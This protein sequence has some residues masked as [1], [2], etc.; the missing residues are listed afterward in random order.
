MRTGIALSLLV[1][2]MMVHPNL[3]ETQQR[4]VYRVGVIL[5]GGYGT[6]QL[7]VSGLASANS[8]LKRGSSLLSQSEIRRAMQR[9]RRRLRGIS[10]KRRSTSYIHMPAPSL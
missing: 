6:R 3:A 2:V 7:T 1:A 5:P 10:N 9:R 8:G 4:R